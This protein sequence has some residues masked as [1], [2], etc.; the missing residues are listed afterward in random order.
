LPRRQ[1]L[2]DGAVGVDRMRSGPIN[3]LFGNWPSGAQPKTISGDNSPI[4]QQPDISRDAQ[5]RSERRVAAGE[6]V[7]HPPRP[8]AARRRSCGRRQAPLAPADAHHRDERLKLPLWLDTCERARRLRRGRRRCTRAAPGTC[9]RTTTPTAGSDPDARGSTR[10]CCR[11]RVELP[12]AA[13]AEPLACPARTD[14]QRVVPP[15]AAP[16][17]RRD[18]RP[19]TTNCFRTP[20]RARLVRAGAARVLDFGRATGVRPI[21]AA[22]PSGFVAGMPT[23]LADSGS[24]PWTV[25]HGRIR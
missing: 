12:P 18:A 7:P 1:G 23:E 20:A 10:A 3:L 14:S 19:P 4:V 13:H 15:C 2:T 11:L 8:A 16:R 5:S 24:L 21:P 25:I 6:R 17:F 22:F 9:L